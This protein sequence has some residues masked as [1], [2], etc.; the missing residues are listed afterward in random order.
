[1]LGKLPRGKERLRK[2]YDDDDSKLAKT[3]LSWITYAERPLTTEKLWQALAV[4]P[5]DTDL[6][7][8][9]ILDVEDFVSVCAGLVTVDETSNIVRLIHYTTQECNGCTFNS[10]AWT[11]VFRR[12]P[13]RPQSGYQR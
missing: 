1:M 7:K 11:K 13:S 2:A 5:G 4:D 6:K 12:R 10:E 9:N 8:D 3:V